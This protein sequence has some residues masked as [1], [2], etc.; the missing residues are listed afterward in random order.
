VSFASMG[1]SEPN[2]R[3]FSGVIVPGERRSC[4]GTQFVINPEAYLKKIRQLVMC[5]NPLDAVTGSQSHY[6]PARGWIK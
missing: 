3:L 1:N 5:E 2:V 4:G 6:S